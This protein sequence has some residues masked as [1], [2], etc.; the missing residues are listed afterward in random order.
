MSFVLVTGDPE[1]TVALQD[2]AD[3]GQ[4][5]ARV[6][7]A[8]HDLAAAVV[9]REAAH[10]RWAW[11]DTAR[12]YLPLL[13]AGVRVERCHDLR[14]CHAILRGSAR[15][16]DSAFALAPRGPWDGPR[17]GAPQPVEVSLFDDPRDDPADGVDGRNELAELQAQLATIAG[18]IEPGRLRLLLA[19]ESSG[20]LI[21]AEMRHDGMPWSVD[22]H[23]ELLTRLLGERPRGGGRPSKLEALADE[24]RSALGQPS[25]NLDSQPDLLRA[26]RSAGLDVTTTR[27]GEIR[28][29]DHPVTA[30][31]VSYTHLTLPTN[32]EV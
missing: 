14:L 31:P 30:P 15:C 17:P 27:T 16:A 5:L 22:V 26:L 29:L 12:W 28:A 11:D 4:P 20:A 7:V 1:R 19:A 9:G 24:V 13:A 6:E 2:V 18:S 23:D 3:D 10:P 32:R 25:L 21:A 8:A